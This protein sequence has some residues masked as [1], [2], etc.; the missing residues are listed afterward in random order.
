M[1]LALN[2]A[3]MANEGFLCAA[4][5]EMQYLIKTPCAEVQEENKRG[6]ELPG[7]REVKAAIDRH[8]A[9]FLQNHTARCLLWENGTAKNPQTCWRCKGI[10]APLPDQC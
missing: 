5:E 1:R 9:M 2:M 6:V 7:H 3:K 8:P 4:I 10:G